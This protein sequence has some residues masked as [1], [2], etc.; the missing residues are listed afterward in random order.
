MADNTEYTLKEITEHNTEKDLWII[1][2]GN[3]YDVTKYTLD[4]PGGL[5][6][7]VE[8]AGQD[9]TQAFEDVGHSDEAREIMAPFLVG[10]LQGFTK[11]T[12]RQAVQ[13]VRKQPAP[14]PSSVPSSKTL[15]T[16]GAASLLAGTATTIVYKLHGRM[17][18]P[19]AHKY[20]QN[21]NSLQ[22]E[23]GFLKGFLLASVLSAAFGAGFTSYISKLTTIPGGFGRSPMYKRVPKL[24][25]RHIVGFLKSTVF[26]PLPLVS[27]QILPGQGLVRLTFELPT[28]MTRLGLPI[29]QHVA[30]QAKIGEQTV[31]RSYTP[32]SNDGDLGK[33]ILLIRLYD[34]GLLTGKYL[35]KLKVGDQVLFRGPKGAMK[36]R[37]GYAK[38]I[39]MVAG[40]TGIT[41]HYQ[42]IRSICE[43]LT[44]T[45]EVSL[46]YANRTEDDI[47]LRAELDAWAKAYP[48]NLKVHYMLDNPP[49]GWLY[50][51]G[52]VTKDIL[53]QYMPAPSNDGSSKILL[54]GPPGMIIAT[55]KNLAELGWKKPGSVG[56]MTD[57][58]FTF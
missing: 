22:S 57:D 53:E 44:D 19:G 26:Q 10:K 8:V 24:P 25:T 43:D 12:R 20:L 39:G 51:S 58:I 14:S 30:I 38:K 27:K 16:I 31:T 50:G 54:C 34:E 52:F 15:G 48:K 37:K 6:S 13:I 40:G 32:T 45:T 49:E 41:P 3:V 47:L 5:E 4:H 56:K 17:H 9:A 23:N 18:I 1:V 29:G 11:S 35:A 46:V 7:L 36:Y 42:L 21:I 33:L 2:D 28:P 55:K